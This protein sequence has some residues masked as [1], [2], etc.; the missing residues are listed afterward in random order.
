MNT[1][2][3]AAIR[4]CAITVLIVMQPAAQRFA[5]PA[6]GRAAERRPT[7]KCLESRQNPQRRVHALLAGVLECKYH[8]EFTNQ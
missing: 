5:L 7:G 8:S 3:G 2:K 4:I 1:L 6:L